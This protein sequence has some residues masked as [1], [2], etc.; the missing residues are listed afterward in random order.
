MSRVPPL[1][2][3]ETSGQPAGSLDVVFRGVQVVVVRV[4]PGGLGLVDD[5]GDAAAVFTNTGLVHR[6]GARCYA[7][8]ILLWVD[9]LTARRAL[10]QFLRWFLGHG[11]SGL[12]IVGVW[13]TG[14][15]P[16][17]F[18]LAPIRTGRQD[19]AVDRLTGFE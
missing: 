11:S 3:G 5:L 14:T 19:A 7:P 16:A 9:R 17:A 18:T 2:I 6:T 1:R 12:S 10:R 4:R 8:L 13:H 15:T